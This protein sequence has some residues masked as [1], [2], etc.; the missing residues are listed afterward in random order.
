MQP[1]TAVFVLQGGAA[2][3]AGAAECET[4]EDRLKVQAIDRDEAHGA[5]TGELR[6]DNQID[7]ATGTVKLK[8]RVPEQ[9]RAG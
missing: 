2:F 9:R 1:I 8:A 6:G 3:G 5:D 4:A 7:A